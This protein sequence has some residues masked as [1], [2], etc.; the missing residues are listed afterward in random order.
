VILW[1]IHALACKQLCTSTQTCLDC[2]VLARAGSLVQ[3]CLQQQVLGVVLLRSTLLNEG[4]ACLAHSLDWLVLSSKALLVLGM[5]SIYMIIHA[6]D[7][8]IAWLHDHTR[9]SK[10]LSVAQYSHDSSISCGE[11]SYAKVLHCD[12]TTHR[13]RC[14]VTYQCMHDRRAISKALL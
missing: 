13:I 3:A 5:S 14:D 11:Q 8:V 10:R 12:Y 4:Q 6:N 2:R 1:Y 9:N 7:H